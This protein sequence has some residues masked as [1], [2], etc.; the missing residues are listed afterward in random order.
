MYSKDNNHCYTI[1]TQNSLICLKKTV[2]L[3]SN[4]EEESVFYFEE[5]VFKK[6]TS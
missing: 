3:I 1:S 4:Q 2:Q 5:N 6:Y